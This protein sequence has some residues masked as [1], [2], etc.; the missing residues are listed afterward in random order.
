[1]YALNAANRA[2]EWKIS[3][4]GAVASGAA[5]ADGTAYRGI[6]YQ[7]KVLGLPYDGDSSNLYAFM[8]S[9]NASRK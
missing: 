3:S 5:I 2:I 9:D 8:V 4:R 6:A 1:M 7:T